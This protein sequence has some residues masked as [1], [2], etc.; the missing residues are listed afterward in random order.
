MAGMVV[1]ELPCVHTA[2]E[3]ASSRENTRRARR[4]QAVK[5]TRIRTMG[6][7]DYNQIPSLPTRRRGTFRQKTRK[8]LSLAKLP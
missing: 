2:G 8:K 3:D 7:N 4:R 5:H 1:C 6:G